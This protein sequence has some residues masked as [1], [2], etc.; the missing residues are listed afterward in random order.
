MQ[1]RLPSF[2]G[3]QEADLQQSESAIDNVDAI[4]AAHTFSNT[5]PKKDDLNRQSI[6]LTQKS[7]VFDKE[8]S[9]LAGDSRE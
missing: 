7:A 3:L 2:E 5:M 9:G 4:Y 6:H 1:Q 8:D